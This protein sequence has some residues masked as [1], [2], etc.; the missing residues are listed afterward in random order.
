MK[1]LKSLSFAVEESRKNLGFQ[2]YKM[3]S[4]FFSKQETDNKSKF[5]LPH[6]LDT[7][8]YAGTTTTC[9]SL[10]MG[11]PCITMGGSVHAHN[12]GVSLLSAVGK[13]PIFSF[14]HSFCSI[15]WMLEFMGEVHLG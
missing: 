9:E 7:F 1:L 15:L 4:L 8:P 12:V 11:V 14:Y 10:Y 3:Y 13:D 5:C 2:S 6:S